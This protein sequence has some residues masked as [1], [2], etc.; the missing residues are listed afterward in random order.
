MIPTLTVCTTVFI[1][2]LMSDYLFGQRSEAGQWWASILYTV[3]PNW[4][5]FWMADALGTEN[6]IPWA[7]VGRAFGYAAAYLGAAL[8]LAL[9]LFEDRELS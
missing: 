9:L 3:M 2:G 4:Q 6:Q 1:V 8:A 7:Y 5:L